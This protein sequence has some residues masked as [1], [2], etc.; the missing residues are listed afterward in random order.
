MPL[1]DRFLG[2]LANPNIAFLLISLGSIA[3]FVELLNPGTWIPGTIGVAFLILGF[4]GV[5]FID[6]SWA[7]V[8]LFGLAILL[9]IL[10]AQAPG[11]SYFGAAA[12]VSLVLGGIFLA[13]PFSGP[14]LAGGAATVSL[15]LLAAVGGSALAFV[16]WL[17]WQIRQAQKAPAYISEGSTSAL[18]GHEGVVTA[19]LAPKGEVHIAGEY[20]T[21]EVAGDVPVEEGETVRVVS[22]EGVSLL[23]ERPHETVS[24]SGGSEPGQSV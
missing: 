13:G 23:V 4:T 5:G 20:W 6:F 14:D 24:V 2:F 22:V 21:A 17:L 11:F 3:L 7:G 15:W 16:L 8:A 19:R 10:E 9:F 12:V 18:V 1:L